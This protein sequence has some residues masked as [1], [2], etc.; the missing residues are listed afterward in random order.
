MLNNR[1]KFLPVHTCV[2]LSPVCLITSHT[3]PCSHKFCLMTYKKPQYWGIS[4]AE[5]YSQR[6]FSE[7]TIHRSTYGAPHIIPKNPYPGAGDGFEGFRQ[8]M[9]AVMHLGGAWPV[10]GTVAREYVEFRW[11]EHNDT[12]PVPNEENGETEWRVRLDVQEYAYYTGPT[13]GIEMIEVDLNTDY[14]DARERI[15]ADLKVKGACNEK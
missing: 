14:S 8:S 3:G 11:T 5:F 9:N 7:F 4:V 10:S 13:E 2:E 1:P 12:Y 6:D 15:I